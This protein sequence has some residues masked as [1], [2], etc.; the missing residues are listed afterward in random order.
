MLKTK[1]LAYA[2]FRELRPTDL[3]YV[4]KIAERLQEPLEEDDISGKLIKPRFKGLV[5]IHTQDYYDDIVGFMVHEFQPEKTFIHYC[6]VDPDFTSRGIRTQMFLRLR[7]ISRLKKKKQVG[8]D[9]RESDLDFH[10]FLK[11]R[12]FKAVKVKRNHFDTMDA[13]EFEGIA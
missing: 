12:G 11:N 1:T 9:V 2:K 6:F 3:P 5:A 8:I 13:Y 4:L 7:T 10:L